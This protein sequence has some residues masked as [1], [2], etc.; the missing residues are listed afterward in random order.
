MVM[1]ERSIFYRIPGPVTAKN[2]KIHKPIYQ[3]II[4]TPKIA[5]HIS[6]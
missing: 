4:P 5:A 6:V 1:S 2:L 3:I